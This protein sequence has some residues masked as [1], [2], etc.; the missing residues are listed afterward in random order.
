MTTSRNLSDEYSN[1]FMERSRQL[2]LEQNLLGEKLAPIIVKDIQEENMRDEYVRYEIDRLDPNYG[3][4]SDLLRY[5]ILHKYGGVYIDC[6]DVAPNIKNP[7]ENTN[8]FHDKHS[9]HVLYVDH[10]SQEIKP[11]K[12]KL[13][14]KTRGSLSDVGNDSFISTKSNPLMKKVLEA[15]RDNYYVAAGSLDERIKL[16][17]SS[18]NIRDITI[19]RT[20]PVVVQDVLKKYVK[21]TQDGLVGECIDGIEK[22]VVKLEY[23]R[24]LDGELTV[25]LENT[26]NWLKAKEEIFVSS[27]NILKSIKDTIDFEV[28]HLSIIRLDDHISNYI[29]SLKL[30][31][32]TTEVDL[33]VLAND[34]IHKIDMNSL[35]DNSLYVQITGKYQCSMDLCKQLNC[36]SLFQLDN[37]AKMLAIRNQSNF[38]SLYSLLELR[39]IDPVRKKIMKDE[40]IDY[41]QKNSSSIDDRLK[42]RLELIV[43][44]SD[45][46]YCGMSNFVKLANSIDILDD[47]QKDL[48][49]RIDKEVVEVLENYLAFN[50]RQRHLES[51]KQ[52]LGFIGCLTE[53]IELIGSNENYKA[54]QGIVTLYKHLGD[55][56]YQSVSEVYKLLS[57]PGDRLSD[58]VEKCN[59]LLSVFLNTPD[60]ENVEIK[61]EVGNKNLGRRGSCCKIS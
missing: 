12:S 8:L 14:L 45:E 35:I 19:E 18:Q 23:I 2:R 6:T 25:P 51:I 37:T 59:A 53:N 34:F 56:L 50:T 42:E 22:H 41:L 43:N 5:N 24:N 48:N 11:K 32:L 57:R 36:E 7:L 39:I 60:I 52:G 38:V 21:E 33:E 15:S 27:D 10:C 46:K 61:E 9:N 44:H 47:R 26:L 31:Q 55:L 28:R 49:A 13:G 54:I 40:I 30:S 1:E 4:S 3:S 29:K 58:P 17:H 16:A 20:G